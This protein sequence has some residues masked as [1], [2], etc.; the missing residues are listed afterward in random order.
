MQRTKAALE[1]LVKLFP[2]EAIVLGDEGTHK[3]VPLEALQ[4][5]D[6][7]LVKPGENVAADGIVLEGSSAIDEI[8]ITGEFM[9]REKALGHTVYA[10]T[11]NKAG[12]LVIR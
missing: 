11:L 6:R 9:P 3:L 8:A 4:V 12:R 10:G 1:S 5:G 7:I 2:K